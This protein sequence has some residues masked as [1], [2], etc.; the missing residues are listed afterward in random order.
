MGETVNGTSASVC[1]RHICSIVCSD[2]RHSRSGG[3]FVTHG[4]YSYTNLKCRCDVCRAAGAEYARKYRER[5]K[6]A[7]RCVE[8]A[9]KAVP[10]FVRCKFHK[11]SHLLRTRDAVKAWRARNRKPPVP[12]TPALP[13]K[14]RQKEAGRCVDCGSE[15]VTGQVRCEQHRRI[16]LEREK[17]RRTA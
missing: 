5:Q 12:R 9:L 7:G 15:A 4:Y 1:S 10:G 13:W 3:R 2:W 16:H 11:A 14:Q 8:C 6:Q 17:A